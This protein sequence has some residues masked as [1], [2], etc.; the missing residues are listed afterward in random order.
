MSLCLCETDVRGTDDDGINKVLQ[1]TVGVLGGSHTVYR[2]G[3]VRA[4]RMGRRG[5]ALKLVSTP[6]EGLSSTENMSL[7]N[8]AMELR[9]TRGVAAA[10]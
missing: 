5:T 6:F 2:S 8:C 1:G 4:L 3:I 9:T 7:G 10:D